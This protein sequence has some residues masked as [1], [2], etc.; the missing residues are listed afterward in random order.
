[1]C[2][3]EENQTIKAIKNEIV[4][5]FNSVGMTMG[6]KGNEANNNLVSVIDKV[7]IAKLG[8]VMIEYFNR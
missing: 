5:S 2:E 8:D 1:M 3:Q 7:D 4:D 6:L